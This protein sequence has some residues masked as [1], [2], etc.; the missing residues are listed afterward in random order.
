MQQNGGFPCPECG[1]M[2]S[3]SRELLLGFLSGSQDSIYCSRCGLK[4]TINP[5]NS[6]EALEQYRQLDEVIQ[7]SQQNVEQAQK[8]HF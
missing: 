6:Q 4:L 2:I 8:G 1:E 3:V 5:E 7:K